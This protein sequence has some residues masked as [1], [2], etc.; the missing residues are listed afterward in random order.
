MTLYRGVSVLI[1]ESVQRGGAPTSPIW[2]V[3]SRGSAPEFPSA[4]FL[5]CCDSEEGNKTRLACLKP[6]KSHCVIIM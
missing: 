4:N 6:A 1:S 2:L 5:N 3:Y